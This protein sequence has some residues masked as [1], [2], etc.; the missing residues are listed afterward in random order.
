MD[1]TDPARLESFLDEITLIKLKAL[2][3]LSHES[4][5]GDPRFLI[6]LTQCANLIR[7]I[8]T[9]LLQQRSTGS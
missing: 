8:Q 4:L 7:K 3:D 2:E 6:F 1:C 9:K 5:R